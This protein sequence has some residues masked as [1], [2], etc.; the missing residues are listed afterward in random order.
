MI[1]TVGAVTSPVGDG[2]VLASTQVS[3]ETKHAIWASSIASK[4]RFIDLSE[5]DSKKKRRRTTVP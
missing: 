4:A 3:P 2:V 1:V 5:Q